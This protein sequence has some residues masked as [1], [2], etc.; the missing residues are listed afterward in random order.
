[1]KAD[2]TKAIETLNSGKYTCV[3]CKDNTI[4]TSA[5]RGVK[6]LID[7]LDANTDLKGFSAADKVVGKAAAFLYV[8]LGADEVYAHVMSEAAIQV[9]TE[10]GIA[11]QYDVSVKNIINRAK[12]GLC[13]MEQTVKEISSPIEAL[14]AV[15]SKLTQLSKGA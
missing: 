14:T 7:W 5:E 6:P 11:C 4:Y 15:R 1:M 8:L 2:L 13:P 10:N 12:T 3:L 9:F